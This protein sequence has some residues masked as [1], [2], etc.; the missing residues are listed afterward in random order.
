[1]ALTEGDAMLKTHARNRHCG[2]LKFAAD[3]AS[4]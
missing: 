4:A 2:A 1:V 3:Q